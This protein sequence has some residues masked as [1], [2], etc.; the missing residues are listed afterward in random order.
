MGSHATSPYRFFRQSLL[1]RSYIHFAVLVLL[2]L[3]GSGCD[4]L[5]P[6]REAAPEKPARAGRVDTPIASSPARDTLPTVDTS[7]SPAPAA[8]PETKIDTISIEGEADTVTLRLVGPGWPFNTYVPEDIA[9]DQESSGDGVSYLFYASYKGKPNR[10]VYMEFFFP[11]KNHLLEQVQ[12]DLTGKRG[13]AKKK[14]WTLGDRQEERCPWADYSYAIKSGKGP[15]QGY[16]CVGRESG[17]V[18]VLT[19]HSP[20]QYVEGF[21][22][23][24]QKILSELRWKRTG[25]GLGEN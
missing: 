18:F 8:R 2:L 20:P 13:V 5:R 6:R 9:T 3:S 24:V 22:P 10:D 15:Q 12:E 23:R 19:V 25:K 7:S 1:Q 17:R 21:M 4:R 11:P 16:I 14:G